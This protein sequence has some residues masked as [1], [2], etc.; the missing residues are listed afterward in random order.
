MPRFQAVIFDW[1]GTTVDYGSRAPAFV[2]IEIFRRRGIEITEPEARGPMGLSKQEHIAAIANLPRVAAAWLKQHGH[3]P[4]A[5][6]VQ[7]MYDEFLP[8]QKETLKNNSEVIPGVPEAVAECR[9][10]G[11]KIGSTTGYTRE[12]MEVVAP[13]AARGGYSPDVIVCSDDVPAGRPAPWMNFQ[14]AQRLGV[15]PM[16]SVLVVDDTSVGIVAGL[17][18]GATTVAVTQTG[19]AVGLTLSEIADLPSGELESR[20]A[21]AD[22]QFREDGADHLLRSVAELPSLLQQLATDG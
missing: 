10:Q 8:L 16:T 4:T 5:D 18:A 21:A 13:I 7:A 3:E 11:L 9:R 15:Y 12:L 1:A 2:F 17:N 6:D 22:R 20:L 19:N 14:V